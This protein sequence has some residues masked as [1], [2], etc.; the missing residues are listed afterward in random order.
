MFFKKG[1]ILDEEKKDPKQEQTKKKNWGIRRKIMYVGF[2][3]F[4]IKLGTII[5]KSFP[6]TDKFVDQTAGDNNPYGDIDLAD[7]K[8]IVIEPFVD[9]TKDLRH[10][11]ALAEDELPID[12]EG[13]AYLFDVGLVDKEIVYGV[14]N[15]NQI[16]NELEQLFGFK[17]PDNYSD[18]IFD[19]ENYL[20]NDDY[21]IE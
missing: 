2:F 5:V 4:T 16:T 13:V 7:L 19:F 12:I 18:I 10:N 9:A 8:A 11:L 14:V 21:P 3:A 1:I 20:V 17:V 15:S 6:S